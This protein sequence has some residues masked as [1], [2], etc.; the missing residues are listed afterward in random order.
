MPGMKSIVGPLTL[1][2]LAV[3][4]CVAAVGIPSCG[5]TNCKDPTNANNAKCVAQQ[6]VVDCTTQSA[7]D[8]VTQHVADL[9]KYFTAAGI[10]WAGVEQA[11]VTLAVD[12]GV[13]VLE[14]VVEH[15]LTPA[16]VTA[17]A[18]TPT[19]VDAGSGVAPPPGPPVASAS[20]A[21]QIADVKIKH[22]ALRAKLWPGKKAKFKGGVR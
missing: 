10:D 18:G 20:S 16:P 4:F 8:F 3:A 17:D 9:E 5:S 2:L 14:A 13:C 12:D 21:V 7:Q 15:Y 1:F 22:Q 11:L 6:A 19:P